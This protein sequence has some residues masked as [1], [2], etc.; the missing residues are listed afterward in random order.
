MLLLTRFTLQLMRVELTYTFFTIYKE[1]VPVAVTLES[2]LPTVFTSWEVSS[3][4]VQCISKR[5]F[6]SLLDV[7][8]RLG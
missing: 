4:P 8:K 1:A 3:Y 2:Y 6:S 5:D 7:I